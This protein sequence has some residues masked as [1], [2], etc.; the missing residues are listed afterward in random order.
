MEKKLPE[1]ILK[2]IESLEKEPVRNPPAIV[3][4]Y[5]YKGRK[6][7]YIPPA[8]GDQMSALYDESCALICRPDGGITG[9]GDGKCAGFP[10]ERS[11]EKIIWKD[12]RK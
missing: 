2:K 11:E 8:A 9:M 4:E 6:V 12:E 1:C 5:Q 7:Y 3:A 10:E